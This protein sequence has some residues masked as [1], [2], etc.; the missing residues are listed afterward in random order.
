MSGIAARTGSA[1]SGSLRRY[2]A[3]SVA[4]SFALV[5]L[6]LTGLFSL[7]EF[8]EQLASVGEG[9]YHVGGALLFV[10][11]TAPARLQQVTPVS[12]LLGCLFAFGA[13]GRQSELVAMLSLGVSER[14]IM[15]SALWPALAAIAALLLL[16]E[17][18]IPPAEELARESRAAALSSE[19]TGGGGSGFWAQRGQEYL[20]V[21]R[22]ERGDVPIDIDIYSFNADGSLDSL[23]HAPRAAIRP[24]G[25]WLLSGASRRV[26]HDGTFSADRTVRLAW[27][28]FVSPRQIQFLILPPDTVPP[29]A[30][31]QHI[32]GLQWDERA[33]RWE[34]ELWA[35]AAMPLSVIA[36]V[37][38]AAPFVFG[39]PR[40]QSGGQNLARGVGVGI[41]YSLGQQI[42]ERLG[43]L[44]GLSAAV[45]ALAPPLLAMA[46]A[47]Y[48]FRR[49]GSGRRRRPS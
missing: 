13:L 27:H 12:M 11:L 49:P 22:F 47:L 28:S 43:L 23:V 42:L 30:L 20:S 32:R 46:A 45:G 44:L 16:M 7:L 19:T 10:L 31:Y 18:V 14:R 6:A 9:H 37:L 25:T 17:F 24:D 15:G 34:Q 5:A 3:M 1:A 40:A 21:Q 38:V 8:V 36:M 4:R 41:A 33:R 2:V 29:L 48:L 39:P 35:Q 26:V